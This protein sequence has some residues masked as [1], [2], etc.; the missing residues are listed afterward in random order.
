MHVLMKGTNSKQKI[1][2]LWIWL[3]YFCT[4]FYNTNIC[5]KNASLLNS[6][7]AWEIIDLEWTSFNSTKSL[8]TNH[9]YYL[10]CC[11][12]NIKHVCISSAI[13]KSL[14]SL[15]KTNTWPFF[16]INMITHG[17]EILICFEVNS[18]NWRT[19]QLIHQ[20]AGVNRKN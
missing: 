7:T 8:R 19:I 16:T 2:N 15:P 18:I 10:R 20:T 11:T 3:N 13:L 14:S 6:F 9:S 1:E 12:F 4:C 5:M 17:G